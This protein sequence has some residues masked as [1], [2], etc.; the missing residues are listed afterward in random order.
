MRWEG[1]KDERVMMRQGRKGG[2]V[3]R[4]EGGRFMVLF[5]SG[6]HSGSP[7]FYLLVSDVNQ[8]NEEVL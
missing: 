4:W 5:K 3:V 6:E 2:R 7:R 8:G 1:A